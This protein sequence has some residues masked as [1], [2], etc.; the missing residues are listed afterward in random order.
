MRTRLAA[1]ATTLAATLGGQPAPAAAAL[2]TLRPG[3]RIDTPTVCTIAY[4]DTGANDHTYAITAGHCAH[5]KPVRVHR[6][7]ATGIFVASV[8]DPPRSGGADY[9]LVDFGPHTLALLFVG[10]RPIA[11]NDHPRPRPGQ[12]VCRAGTTTGQQCGTIAAAYGDHQYLTTGMPSSR[13]GDSGGPV[14]ILGGDGRA[15]VI[16]I[17]LGGR[18]TADGNDYGRFA[19]LSTAVATLGVPATA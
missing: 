5:G 16:G 14:W 13:G 17:W 11:A 19:A 15:Q 7:C 12:T 3:D 2:I 6:S 9:G 8:V 1:A 18:S 4:T 10:N